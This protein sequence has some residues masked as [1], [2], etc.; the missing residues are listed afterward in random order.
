MITD[1]ADARVQIGSDDREAESAGHSRS[2][3]PDGA[4]EGK[5]QTVSGRDFL[6]V[7]STTEVG[8][9]ESVL[10][11]LFRASEELRRRSVVATLGY[12]SG[13]LPEQL[14]R[15]GAL[16]ITFKMPRL[17]YGWRLL[18][19]FRDLRALVRRA[20]VRAIVG[21]G[22]HP[23]AVGGVLARLSGARSVFL[24]HQICDYPLRAN[25]P[26]LVAALLAPCDL[27]IAVSRAAET[28][29]ARLR[30][31]TPHALVHNGTAVRDVSPAE[32]QTARAELGARPADTL[33]GVF[34]RLQRSKGHDVLIDAFARIARDRPNLRLAVVGGSV[35][36]L[37]PEY[38]DELKRAVNRLGLGDRTVFTGFRSDIPRLMAACDIVCNPSRAPE[39][40]GMAVVE[41]MMLGRPV[42]AAAGGG[43]SEIIATEE[44]GVLVPPGDVPALAAALAVLADDPERR[45]RLGAAARVRARSEFSSDVMAA[46]LI[47]RLDELVGR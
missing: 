32:A 28:A 3:L 23:S 34:G 4:T 17:R 40:F 25:D 33:I 42:V 39:S 37:E 9:A 6:F 36:G 29:V 31:R 41:A 7:Q 35:F 46:T 30:P 44:H 47:H 18:P 26:R 21:N 16:V 27:L 5:S 12:G 14:R 43:P 22:A 24:V 8:G 15:A 38:A 20:G 11:N 10:L 19:V 1:A 13:D 45:R 2:I